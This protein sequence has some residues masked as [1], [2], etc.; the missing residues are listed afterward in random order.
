MT[1]IFRQ[2]RP[3]LGASLGQIPWCKGRSSKSRPGSLQEG[4]QGLGRQGKKLQ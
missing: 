4:K 3:G 2:I 1:M